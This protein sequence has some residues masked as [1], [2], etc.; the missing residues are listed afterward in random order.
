MP[1]KKIISMLPRERSERS[2]DPDEPRSQ[3]IEGDFPWHDAHTH[4]Q[5][6]PSPDVNLWARAFDRFI[7][8]LPEWIVRITLFTVAL[9]LIG[10]IVLI[11][12]DVVIA[13]WR[14]IFDLYFSRY[15]GTP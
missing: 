5:E 12:I 2:E 3:L 13:T 15:G 11:M 8:L 6:R 1:G 7:T 4:R 10:S 14:S 9:I